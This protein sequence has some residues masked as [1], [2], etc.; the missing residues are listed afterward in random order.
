MAALDERRVLARIPRLDTH[1]LIPA[2]GDRREMRVDRAPRAFERFGQRIRE[3]LVLAAP[4]AVALHHDAAAKDA[5]AI[6]QRGQRLAFVARKERGR[7]GAA[8]AVELRFEIGPV[9]R[10]DAF[11]D[12]R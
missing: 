6:V 5:V 7:R 11:A 9:E 4:E 12:V 3:V 2:I 8:V 1:Y 10:V